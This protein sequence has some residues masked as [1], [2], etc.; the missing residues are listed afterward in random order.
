MDSKTMYEATCCIVT[1][2]Y[3]QTTSLWEGNPFWKYTI[4]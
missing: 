3:L 2:Y 1:H 4:L